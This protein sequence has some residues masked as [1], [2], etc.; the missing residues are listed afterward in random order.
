[1][2]GINILLDF[3]LVGARP[4]SEIAAFTPACSPGVLDDPGLFGIIV[5]D[6]SDGMYP[7]N[8]TGY[9]KSS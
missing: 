4:D 3:A 6:D 8:K 5:T 9:M 7:L 1:V 2:N